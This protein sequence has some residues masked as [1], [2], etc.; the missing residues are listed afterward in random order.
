MKVVEK[1]NWFLHHD[2]FFWYFLGF[3]YV[4]I[5]KLEYSHCGLHKK[6]ALELTS[7][8]EIEKYPLIFNFLVVISFL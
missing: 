4:K 8:V 2:L 1:F 7:P 3:I 6:R 5:I